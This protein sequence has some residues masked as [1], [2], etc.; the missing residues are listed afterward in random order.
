MIPNVTMIQAAL[1]EQRVR[2][3]ARAKALDRPDLVYRD[4]DRASWV[5]VRATLR[6]IASAARP[7]K[8][9]VLTTPDHQ[10]TVA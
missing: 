5:V 10:P 9:V 7:R 6:K 1:T 8:R 2:D 4:P 3:S